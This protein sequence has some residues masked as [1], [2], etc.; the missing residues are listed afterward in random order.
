M[1]YLGTHPLE[2]ATLVASTDVTSDT[3]SVTLTGIFEPEVMYFINIMDFRPKN[4]NQTLMFRWL[5]SGDS[6]ISISNYQ[7]GHRYGFSGGAG[8]TGSVGNADRT[9]GY[10]NLG[11]GTGNES[12]EASNVEMWCVPNTANE[13]MAMFKTNWHR[14]TE[15]DYGSLYVRGSRLNSS[16]T[17]A[18]GIEF[19]CG[20]NTGGEEINNVSIRVYKLGT[21]VNPLRSLKRR[22]TDNWVNSNYI[23]GAIKGQG[24]AKVAE[25]TAADGDSALDFTDVFTSNYKR[26]VITGTDCRPSTAD[27]H[28]YFQYRDAG[29]L[30]TGTYNSTYWIAYA[31]GYSGAIQSDDAAIPLVLGSVGTINNEAGHFVSFLD[32]ISTNTPKF[33]SYRSIQQHSGGVKAT[34][35]ITGAVAYNDATVMTG[36]KW[37]WSSGNWESGTIKIY[38]VND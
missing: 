21:K 35:Y 34:G 7:E 26:Y 29:G 22:H 20:A 13:K 12:D 32:P 19:V 9:S 28:L 27:K 18:E 15:E 16:A 36:I 38:G 3:A 24:W 1:E 31:N 5:D 37:Y 30:N 11:S 25:M 2:G 14:G 6:A 8:S 17:R 4:N 10:S 33:L 23:G